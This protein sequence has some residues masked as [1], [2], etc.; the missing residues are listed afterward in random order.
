MKVG[1]MGAGAIGCYLGGRL[2]HSG[3][4][5]VLVGRQSLADE[6]A[7]H[8][9][10]LTDYRGFDQTLRLEVA[11][12][13]TALAD[14]DVVL[15]TVKGG[16]TASAGAALAGVLRRDALVVSFQNGVNNPELLRAALPQQ[17]VLAGMVPFNVLRR[18]GAHFHQGTSGRLA[19]ERVEAVMPLVR[20][21]SHAGLEIEAHDDMRGVL[22][23]KLLVNL[24]N[25]VNALANIPIKEMLSQRDY[26]R[27]MAACVREGLDAVSAAGIQPRLDVPLPPR[28]VPWVLTLPDAVFSLVARPML[29]VDPQ[30]RSS[31]WDDLARGRKTEIDA[32]NGEV[33]RLAEKV[34]TRATVN[35]AIVALVKEAEGR[36]SPGLGA[37]ALR[38]KLGVY[39]GFR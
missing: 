4:P 29:T 17:R 19:V 35:A 37:A 33:V 28:L 18:A 30:A 9:M 16:D 25:P 22:W 21:L 20:A 13:P 7:Q 2:Q 3:V 38:E 32:L 36:G 26:R 34:G 6:V 23:G 31:M 24:N 5:V 12:A 8:G 39:S 15:V 27:V 11:T 14:C 1:I 10:H